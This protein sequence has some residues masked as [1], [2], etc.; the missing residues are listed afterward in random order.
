MMKLT[1]ASR[2]FAKAPKKADSLT[3][4]G[5]GLQKTFIYLFRLEEQAYNK[6]NDSTISRK[7][8]PH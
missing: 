8:F 6:S 2:N 7:R 5:T 1:V 4:G 3:T